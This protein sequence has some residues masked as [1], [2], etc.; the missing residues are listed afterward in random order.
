MFSSPTLNPHIYL[1]GLF[2]SY[3]L[4]LILFPLKLNKL[5]ELH[6]FQLVLCS[7]STWPREH[8]VQLFFKWSSNPFNILD[9]ILRYQPT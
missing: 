8:L 7:T 4:K 2:Y 3:V 5:I 1:Y 6:S 9:G